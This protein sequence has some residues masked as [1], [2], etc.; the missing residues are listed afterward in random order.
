MKQSKETIMLT[1]VTIAPGGH[2]ESSAIMNALRHEGYDVEECMVTGGG[3]ALAFFFQEG[4]FPFLGG[5]NDDM[6]ERFFAASK[7]EWHRGN[8][9]AKDLG[10]S[11]IEGLLKRGIPVII[12]NDMRYMT[13]RYAGRRGP[14]YASFGG[15]YVALFGVDYDKGLAYVSDTEYPGLQTVTLDNLKR[16]RSSKTKTFPPRGEFYWAEKPTA[17]FRIDM[18]SLARESV[19]TVV[20][21]YRATAEGASESAGKGRDR[22]LVG[23][24][25][26]ERYPA[27]LAKLE[28]WSDKAFLLPAVLE[29]MASNIEDFGT[30]GASFRSLYRDFLTCATSEGRCPELAPLIPLIDR[31]I[32]SWHGLSGEFRTAAKRIKGMTATQRVEVYSRFAAIAGELHKNETAFYTELASIANAGGNDR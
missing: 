25:G 19:R 15:H 10:W 5:R 4:T 14:A 7:I 21:N 16:G 3:G 11:V 8:A 27:A 2:C 20:E 17:G 1:G 29:Y 31:S 9:D 22:A 12:R 13:Y 32:D 26:L 6:K 24:G 23:L 18:E 30:G 28:T